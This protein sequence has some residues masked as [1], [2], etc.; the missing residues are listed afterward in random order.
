ML[1]ILGYP[2]SEFHGRR[3]KIAY[4]A[5]PTALVMGYPLMH[6]PN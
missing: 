3:V 1:S 5:Y 6:G 4:P 2:L